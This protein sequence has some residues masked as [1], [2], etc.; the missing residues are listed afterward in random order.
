MI[1]LGTVYNSSRQPFGNVYSI[2]IPEVMA[3]VENLMVNKIR[4]LENLTANMK[5]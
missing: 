3:D 4:C 5:F 2:T 1:M